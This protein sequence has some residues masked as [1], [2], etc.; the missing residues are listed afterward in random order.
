MLYDH[1]WCVCG[2]GFLKVLRGNHYYFHNTIQLT[3]WTKPNSIKTQ[4]TF[5]PKVANWIPLGSRQERDEG[6]SIS[7]FIHKEFILSQD[8]PTV[9][10]YRSYNPVKLEHSSATHSIVLRTMVRTSQNWSVHISRLILPCKNPQSQ[11]F[12]L[13]CLGMRKSTLFWG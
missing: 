13:S 2:G 6:D 9:E 4:H 8:R 7:S 5:F 1:F 11:L 3:C 12:I 10:Q